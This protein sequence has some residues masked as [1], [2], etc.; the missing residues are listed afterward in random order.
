[1]A[2]PDK[3]TRVQKHVRFT[4]GQTYAN[5]EIVKFLGPRQFTYINGRTRIDYVYWVTCKRCGL[6]MDYTEEAIRKRIYNETKQCKICSRGQTRVK[7]NAEKEI[8]H[9]AR[10]ATAHPWKPSRKDKDLR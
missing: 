3:K 5:L 9:L 6:S 10:W 2:N 4:V 8:Y 1:M 7:E